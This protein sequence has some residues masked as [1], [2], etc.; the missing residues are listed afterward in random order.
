MVKSPA[1]LS[2]EPN[3]KTGLTPVPLPSTCAT[4]SKFSQLFGPQPPY[5]EA[6]DECTSF[7]HRAAVV[8][9]HDITPKKH[10]VLALDRGPEVAE[11][12]SAGPTQS[13]CTRAE[14]PL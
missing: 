1:Y 2:S 11:S 5:L 8:R 13:T 7:P 4:L 14:F 9:I 10:L 3:P 12:L 6:E